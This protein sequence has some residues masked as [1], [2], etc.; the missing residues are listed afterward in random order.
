MPSTLGEIVVPCYG[1]TAPLNQLAVLAPDPGTIRVAM[2]DRSLEAEVE[3][4][5]FKSGLGMFPRNE[6]TGVILVTVPSMR[7]RRE[8]LVQAV[9]SEAEKSRE[10]VRA[11]GQEATDKLDILLRDKKIGGDE[12][13]VGRERVQRMV[14][15]C[16]GKIDAAEAD[17]RTKLMPV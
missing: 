2:Y 11:I 16:V 6:G 10:A 13:R 4:A 17:K 14:G 12:A 1:S 5:I 3:K 7:E 15:S 8:A 9:A